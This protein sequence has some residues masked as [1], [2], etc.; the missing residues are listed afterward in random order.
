MGD[1][2]FVYETSNIKKI[3]VFAITLSVL[4]V[5]AFFAVTFQAKLY[6]AFQ[7]SFIVNSIEN[8]IEEE[9]TELTP[10]GLFYAGVLG[11]SFII[12]S[13]LEILFYLALSRGS[14]VLM[15]FLLLNLGLL[16]IQIVNYWLGAKFSPF[17]LNFLSPKKVYKIRRLTNKYGAFLVF[18]VSLIPSLPYEVLTFALGIAKYNYYRL[19]ILVTLGSL[20]KYA[21]IAGIFILLH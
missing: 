20:I 9:I 7:D 17:I 14:D 8:L 10:M 5:V 16:L 15:S 13:P 19:F 18:F 1:Y 6:L 4:I 11:G 21:I 2:Y 12:P 3:K